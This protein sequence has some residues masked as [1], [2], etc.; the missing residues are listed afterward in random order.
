MVLTTQSGAPLIPPQYGK[1]VPLR[2]QCAS[3]H[4]RLV[5][6]KVNLRAGATRARLTKSGGRARR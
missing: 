2:T 6:K 4:A 3:V 1:V 5:A